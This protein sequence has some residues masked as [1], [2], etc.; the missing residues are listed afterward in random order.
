MVA[1]YTGEHL[2]HQRLLTGDV[3]ALAEAYDRYAAIV[4]GVALRV[5]RDRQAAEDVTQETLM[6]LW[7]RP[8]RFDPGRGG[9]R[10]W[11]ATIAH[12]R[13]V[14]WIRHE[15]AARGRDLRNDRLMME[16]VPDIGDDVQA[17]MTAERVQRALSDLPECE[18]R[19][20]RL[21][22][23]GGLSYRQVAEDLDIPE[24]TIKSRIRSGLHHLSHTMYAEP[25]TA[26]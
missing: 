18:S 26:P 22:F 3:N 7:H 20:I 11:L 10:P 13:S 21:A 14:D 1:S 24:G 2:L 16:P 19:A 4:F 5:T 9:L 12:N 6:E 17:T 8:Q 23:F 25:A 15:R